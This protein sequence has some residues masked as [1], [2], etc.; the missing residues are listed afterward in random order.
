MVYKPKGRRF[1]IVKFVA[2]GKVIQKR[3]KATNEKAA[4][5]IEA[6]LRNALALGDVGI[7]ERKP[8]PPLAEFL[9]Q[10]FLPYS[11]SKF[12]DKP[13]TLHYYQ[14]GVKRLL[15]SEIGRLRLSEI[16]DQHARQFEAHWSLF[17]PSTI[18]CG[19][20]APHGLSLRAHG[21]VER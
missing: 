4:R 21:R 1:Y 17:S 3:T 7:F 16:T 19:F 8:A 13:G 15:A 9:K 10:D 12:N 11:E 14:D 20:C 5:K 6:A 2:D 18:N